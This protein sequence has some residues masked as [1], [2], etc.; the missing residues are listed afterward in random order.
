MESTSKQCDNVS[1]ALACRVAF[2]EEESDLHFVHCMGLVPAGST[3]ASPMQEPPPQSPC[4]RKKA[5]SRED[6]G[7]GYT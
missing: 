1:L 6:T 5:V 3:Q 2:S 7:G 4:L